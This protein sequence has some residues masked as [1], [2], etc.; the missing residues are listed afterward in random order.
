MRAHVI[1]NPESGTDRA[2]PMLP[3]ITE[4]LRTR[5]DEVNVTITTTVDDAVRGAARAMEEHCEAVYVA[6]GDGTVNAALQGL[7]RGDDGPK[8]PIGVIPFGTG[9]DF[10]KALGLGEEPEAALDR[11]L[12]LRVIDVDVGLMNER[13]FINTSAGGFI[14][15]VSEIVTPAL[16]D[17][18]GKLAYLIG[19][20]RV[21]MSSEPIRMRLHLPPDASLDTPDADAVADMQMFIV[22][23]APFIGGGYA[24]RPAAMIDDGL[25]DGLVVPRRSL[26][27]FAAV[28]QRLAAAGGPANGDVQAFRASAFDL[29][30]D[31]PIHVNVDGEVL[32]VDRCRYRVRR[33]AAR[34]FC[35]PEPHATRRGQVWFP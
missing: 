7:L 29:E 25:L 31:R 27:E 5:F 28:L 30:F 13:P 35:G 14:A 8:A 17:V 4:R 6:G 23:N 33:R 12:D 32:E 10:S 9:N 11:L 19:G 2:V 22:C 34:F 3:L 16:K 18:A 20:A 26:L 15:D 24:V 21:L 1:V